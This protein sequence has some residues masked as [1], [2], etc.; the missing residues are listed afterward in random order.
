[1]GCPKSGSSMVQAATNTQGTECYVGTPK[2]CS[3]KDASQGQCTFNNNLF[4]TASLLRK[5]GIVANAFAGIL[6]FVNGITDVK[7]KV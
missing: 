3:C 4:R 1:M 5:G 2:L 7:V 6:I